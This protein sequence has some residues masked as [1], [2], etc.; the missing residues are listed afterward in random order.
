MAAVGV[1]VPVGRSACG[2]IHVLF[3]STGL[4]T[5]VL[6]VAV[7]AR[8]DTGSLELIKLMELLP[9]FGTPL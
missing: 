6:N 7:V 8:I 1:I 4:N 2:V 3:V 5:V 9:R